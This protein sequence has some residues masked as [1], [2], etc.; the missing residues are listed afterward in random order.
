MRKKNE[1][2]IKHDYIEYLVS[3]FNRAQKADFL[4]FIYTI[5]RVEGMS[6]GH[7]DPMI[8]VS[9]AIDDFNVLLVK[10]AKKREYKRQ[11]RLALLMY[12]HAVEMSAPYDI[13]TNLL[14]CID[15][16]YYK[17]SPFQHLRKEKKGSLFQAPVSTS[18]KV[19]EIRK[20]ALEIGED[21]LDEI[22]EDIYNKDIRNA[23]D[24]SDY[25]LSNESFHIVGSGP[26]FLIPI[27]DILVLVN[28]ALSF[29]SAFFNVYYSYKRGFYSSD[30]KRRLCKLPN[31]EVFEL[32][33]NKEEGLY[34]FHVHFS[35]GQKATFERHKEEVITDNISFSSGGV[36]F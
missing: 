35:N 3:L 1:N 5:L 25:C 26:G 29:Y 2:N 11:L 17:I 18:S 20:L 12:C 23:F 31:Y 10:C 34:G 28:R 22:F 21:R 27:D 7:W 6:Q 13:L 36:D 16:S 19:K 15:K 4:E 30:E 8:E 24:H 33:I 32:L 14:A 9:E